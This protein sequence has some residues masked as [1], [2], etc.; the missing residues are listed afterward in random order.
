MS[1]NMSTPLNGVRQGSVLSPSLFNL[2][3]DDLLQQLEQ[4]GEGARLCSQ[5]AGALAY[6]DDLSLLS[7]TVS[8]MQNIC[9]AYA[10]DHGLSFSDKNLRQ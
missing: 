10:E 5:Y 4:S 7:P 9:V 6:A 2:Y 3:V 8:G 1:N